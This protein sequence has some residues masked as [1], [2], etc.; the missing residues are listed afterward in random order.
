MC[1]NQTNDI[2]L[3]KCDK[4][5]NRWKKGRRGKEDRKTSI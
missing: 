2:V 3:Q 4:N 5:M 1:M